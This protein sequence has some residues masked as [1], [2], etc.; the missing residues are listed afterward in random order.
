MSAYDAVLSDPPAPVAKVNVRNPLTAAVIT[1]VSMLLDTGA[2]VTLIPRAVEHLQ[3][4]IDSAG[5]YQLMG[6]DGN[7]SVAFSVEA[8]VLFLSHAF[9]GRF[10]LTDQNRGIL[11]RDVLNRL[12]ILFDGPRLAW[13]EH[14][15]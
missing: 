7:L 8:D 11:G 6:F 12:P 5:G 14:T 3:I 2:D 13:S 15:Q 4:S 1:D 9:K 10:L